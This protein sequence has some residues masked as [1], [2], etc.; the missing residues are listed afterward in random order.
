MDVWRNL[1][2]LKAAVQEGVKEFSNVAINEVRTGVQTIQ[3]QAAQQ[4]PNQHDDRWGGEGV[5]GGSIAV[6][7][8]DGTLSAQRG[9]RR[10]DDRAHTSGLFSAPA[11]PETAIPPSHP[12]GT[13]ANR[14][15]TRQ[16]ADSSSGK[17]SRRGSTPSI[18]SEAASD[19]PNA[20]VPAL[21]QSATP[22]QALSPSG[23]HFVADPSIT[24]TANG[25]SHRRPDQGSTNGV[26]AAIVPDAA[27]GGVDSPSYAFNTRSRTARTAETISAEAAG[28]T[29]ASTARSP[30]GSGMAAAVPRAAQ[31]QG[32]PLTESSGFEGGAP[33][34]SATSAALTQIAASGGMPT[35]SSGSTPSA[36]SAGEPAAAG[37]SARGSGGGASNNSGRPPLALATGS[38]AVMPGSALSGF[39]ARES[40]R[41]P[42]AGGVAGDP[43]PGA[44]RSAFESD[45][46]LRKAYADMKQ[47]Y[48]DMKSLLKKSMDE[49]VRLSEEVVR[50]ESMARQA[51]AQAAEQA[52]AARAAKKEAA[53]ANVALTTARKEAAAA[54]RTLAKVKAQLEAK[55]QQENSKAAETAELDVLHGELAAAVRK[56]MA[57]VA[58]KEA[59]EARAAQSDTA[60]QE[61]EQARNEA[62]R[63]RREA[64]AEAHAALAAAEAERNSRAEAQGMS[65]ALKVESERRARVF[66]NAVKA[67]VGKVQRELEAERDEL[68]AQL[69]A[70][71]RSLGEIKEELRLAL[72][73]ADEAAAEA[74]ARTRDAAAAG[75]LAVAAEAA[76]ERAVARETEAMAAAQA[77]EAARQQLQAELEQVKFDKQESDA[78]ARVLDSALASLR[79]QTERERSAA[80]ATASELE[81]EL[82][83][84]AERAEAATS[85]LAG[86]EKQLEGVTAARRLDYANGRYSLRFAVLA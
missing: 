33:G 72:A 50:V 15:G 71:L 54:E 66:N 25:T 49:C 41:R 60:R 22:T 27:T 78:R 12:D 59:A 44:G 57:A 69:R 65:E 52:S 84:Q 7:E 76:A 56:A 4:Q 77:A 10:Q 1:E 32:Q 24:S 13:G 82:R 9:S 75:T 3:Q 21:A 68:Q 64:E 53:D 63:L 18:P 11:P 20:R 35:G 61:A 39:S 31:G 86:V 83:R 42:S 58:A 28:A 37:E 47:A 36:P 73:A 6:A 38:A 19:K 34:Q 81:R 79:S 43:G 30:P 16:E 70:S 74:E 51:Q 45:A 26:A 23:A 40:S 14:E 55:E 67:A 17:A 29:V 62:D 8:A 48:D 2:Q 85:A 5:V 46:D 80:A